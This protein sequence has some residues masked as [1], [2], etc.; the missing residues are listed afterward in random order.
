MKK[1]ERSQILQV[2]QDIL[3]EPNLR[4]PKVDAEIMSEVIDNL[5]SKITTEN[6]R[7]MHKEIDN[8][9]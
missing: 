9:T 1:N 7:I 8:Q 5:S 3:E 2:L 6:C 4:M